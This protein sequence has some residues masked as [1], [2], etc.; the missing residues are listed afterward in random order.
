[1]A[2]TLVLFVRRADRAIDRS[3]CLLHSKAIVFAAGLHK[4]HVRLELFDLKK[5]NFLA[6]HEVTH[7]GELI[8]L[9]CLTIVA[10]LHFVRNPIRLRRNCVPSPLSVAVVQAPLS[11]MFACCTLHVIRCRHR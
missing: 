10:P 5:T 6:A 9:E 8:A 1:M 7:C 4:G 11:C 3:Q 2:R